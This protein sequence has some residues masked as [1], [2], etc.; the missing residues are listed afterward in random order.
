LFSLS[1]Q[2]I[3]SFVVGEKFLNENLMLPFIFFSSGEHFVIFFA[4]PLIKISW[5]SKSTEIKNYFVAKNK[6]KIFDF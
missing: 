3:K 5:A 6:I 4:F 1:K 2:K